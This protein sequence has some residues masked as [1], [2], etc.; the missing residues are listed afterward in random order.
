VERGVAVE[1]VSPSSLVD[2]CGVQHHGGVAAVVGPRRLFDGP[3]F[4]DALDGLPHAPLL[5]AFEGFHDPHNLGYALRSIEAFGADGVLLTPRDWGPEEAVISQSSSGAYDRLRVGTL[6]D[7]RSLLKA[8]EQK[9]I[10]SVAA[11]AGAYRSFYDFNL[12]APVLIA[13][14]GEFRGL[15]DAMKKWCRHT[16]HLPMA[17]TIPSFP[18]SQAAAILA[19]EAARQRRAGGPPG[20]LWPTKRSENPSAFHPRREKAPRPPQR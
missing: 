15:S 12:R 4:L 14:G 2:L 18:A 6:D 19:A 17:D 10:E 1:T 13:V 16:A 7:A 20:P 9:G 3:E 5:F 11:T 8:L